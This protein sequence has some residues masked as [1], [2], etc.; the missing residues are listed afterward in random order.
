MCRHPLYVQIWGRIAGCFCWLDS[1][2]AFGEHSKDQ[3]KWDFSAGFHLIE[4][5]F[6]VCIDG[7]FLEIRKNPS[8]K[9]GLSSLEHSS[10]SKE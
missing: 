10:K 1:Y 3:Y 5:L 4:L 2:F 7:N 6:K 8:C 9:L